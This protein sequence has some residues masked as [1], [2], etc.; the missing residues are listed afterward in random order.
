MSLTKQSQ[1]EELSTLQGDE[2]DGSPENEASREMWLIACIGSDINQLNDCVIAPDMAE[3]LRMYATSLRA[4]AEKAE[5]P[6]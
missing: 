1:P 2:L 5:Q 6:F 3:Q 4:L